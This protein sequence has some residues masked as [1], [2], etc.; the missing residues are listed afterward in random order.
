MFF[1]VGQVDD[2]QDLEGTLITCQSHLLGPKLC[3]SYLGGPVCETMQV[4]C[5][6]APSSTDPS[7]DYLVIRVDVAE[8]WDDGPNVKT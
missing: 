3:Y 2:R 1:L 8:S 7:L 4:L 5:P 6:G